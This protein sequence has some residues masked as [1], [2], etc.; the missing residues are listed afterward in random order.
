MREKD[1]RDT[2]TKRD[3]EMG[4]KGRKKGTWRKGSEKEVQLHPDDTKPRLI[5]RGLYQ[6][7]VNLGF[8]KLSQ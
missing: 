7:K 5:Q 1:Q 3:T 4:G 6:I 2:E 8:L